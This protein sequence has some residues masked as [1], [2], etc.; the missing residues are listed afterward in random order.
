VQRI[1]LVAAM[2]MEARPLLRR[3]GARS[4][5]AVEGFPCLAFV[6]VG[7]DCRLVASGMGFLRASRAARALLSS[8]SPDLLVSFGIAGAPGNDLAV[9]DVVFAEKIALIGAGP[10]DHPGRGPWLPVRPSHAAQAA[11]AAA[12][13]PLGARLSAGIILTTPGTQGVPPAFSGSRNVVLEMETAAV[14]E[15][16]AERGIPL[17]A[18]R[19]VSDSASEPLPFDLEAV[20]DGGQDMRLGRIVAGLAAHPSRLPAALRAGRNAARAAENL[21]IAMIAALTAE[22]PGT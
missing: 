5:P 15:A 4:L 22:L 3:G 19:A 6:L 2:R 10:D 21:A 14:A 13:R 16:A 20:L 1:G 9:G 8:W 17:L 18:L 11:A 12:L 7:H